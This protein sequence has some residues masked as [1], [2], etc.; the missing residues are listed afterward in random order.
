[1]IW[2]MRLGSEKWVDLP[3][4]TQL[5]QYKIGLQPTQPDSSTLLE[6]LVSQLVVEQ[7]AGWVFHSFTPLW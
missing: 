6:T 3:Q 5:A 4:D 1:M 7:R 2:T